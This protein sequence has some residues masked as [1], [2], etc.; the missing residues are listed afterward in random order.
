[1]DMSLFDTGSGNYMLLKKVT[2]LKKSLSD[3]DINVKNKLE[4]LESILLR[5]RYYRKSKYIK[6]RDVKALYD[7]LSPPEQRVEEEQYVYPDGMLNI[8]IRTRGEPDDYQMVG[9]LYNTSANK[10]YQLFGR[11]TYPGSPEWEYYIRG[12]DAGGLDFKFPLDTRRQEIMEHTKLNIPLDD[13][14]YN[15]KIYNYDQP[16]YN[17]F[18]I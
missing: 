2:D 8:N 7:P 1:M 10:N 6:E 4:D 18:I 12:R 11:R 14:V 17:P 13:M 16:R 9:L 5:E 15:V 3:A